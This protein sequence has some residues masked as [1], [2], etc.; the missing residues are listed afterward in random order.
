MHQILVRIILLFLS[1]LETS[2]ISRL[3]HQNIK[4]IGYIYPA[5]KA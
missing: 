1:A 4:E 5:L 2:M 3:E